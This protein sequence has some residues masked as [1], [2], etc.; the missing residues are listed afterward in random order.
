[1]S[2][3]ATLKGTQSLILQAPR[4]P[5]QQVQSEAPGLD[6]PSSASTAQRNPKLFPYPACI[7]ESS[8]PPRG[9]K[10]LLQP[11]A[12]TGR[13]LLPAHIQQHSFSPTSRQPNSHSSWKTSS[14]PRGQRLVAPATGPSRGGSYA[15][16]LVFRIREGSDIPVNTD[17]ELISNRCWQEG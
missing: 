12:P 10:P 2:S 15:I 8:F 6:H 1:M 17:K 14:S 11:P 16:L 9:I 13:P 7:S 4:Q 5:L 3:P